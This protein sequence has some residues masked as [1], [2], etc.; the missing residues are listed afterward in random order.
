MLFERLQSR[1]HQVN[2]SGRPFITMIF[3]FRVLVNPDMWQISYTLSPSEAHQLTS[4]ELTGA[5]V[6]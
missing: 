6:D 3:M 1:I 2:E 4:Y 5:T